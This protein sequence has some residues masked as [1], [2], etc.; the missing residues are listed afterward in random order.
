MSPTLR[1]GQRVRLES[2]GGRS[3]DGARRTGCVSNRCPIRR[4]GSVPGD[5]R[6]FGRVPDAFPVN[7]VCPRRLSP[8]AIP[9]ADG[10][11]F[12]VTDVTTYFPDD[13]SNALAPLAPKLVWGSRGRV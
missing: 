2:F 6:R 7:G 13:P 12:L 1:E 5:F 8:T 10:A 11:A 3:P 4:S 9:L